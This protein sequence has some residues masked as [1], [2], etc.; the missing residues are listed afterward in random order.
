M[1]RGK[2][3]Q[4]MVLANLETIKINLERRDSEG[5]MRYENQVADLTR[6]VCR[7]KAKLDSN[8]DLKAA[9]EK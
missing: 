8:A 6:Q 9:E 1:N 5:K 3:S 2:T 7:L 4:A